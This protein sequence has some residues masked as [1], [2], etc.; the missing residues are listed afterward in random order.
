M[1]QRTTLGEFRCR[2]T[3]PEQSSEIAVA[4]NGETDFFNKVFCFYILIKH[5]P[6]GR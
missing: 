5:A 6:D 4:E 1:A 3:A 2:C